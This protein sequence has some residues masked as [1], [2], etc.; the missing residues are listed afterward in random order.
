MLIISISLLSFSPKDIKRFSEHQ[1]C[2]Q[3]L[4]IDGNIAAQGGY[5]V[6]QIKMMWEGDILVFTH[7][8]KHWYVLCRDYDLS[9]GTI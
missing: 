6:W 5:M 9:S 1:S 2:S 4:M 8:F 7:Q 3:S